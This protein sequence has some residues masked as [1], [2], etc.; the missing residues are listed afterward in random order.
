VN[1]DKIPAKFLNLCGILFLSGASALVCEVIWGRMLA[2]VLGVTVYGA[3]IVLVSFML[4]L[5][6]GSYAGGKI[7]DRLRR[8]GVFLALGQLFVCI[9]AIISPFLL[10]LPPGSTPFGFLLAGFL[11]LP[12]S[13]FWGA[14][15]P[16]AGALCIIPADRF[17][18]RLTGILN[19]VNTAGGVSGAAAA[20]FLLGP[21]LGHA[22]S[23]QFAAGLSLTASLLAAAGASGRVRAAS[24]AGSPAPSGPAVAGSSP[25]PVS[26]PSPGTLGFRKI[27]AAGLFFLSGFTALGYEVLWTRMLVFYIH[28][29]VYAF[30]AMLIC[31][32]AGLALGSGIFALFPVR[33]NPVTILV[34]GLIGTAASVA[35]SIRM[36]EFLP[37]LSSVYCRLAGPEGWLGAVGLVLL[38]TAVI[39]LIPVT[40]L[41]L[42]FPS[43]AAILFRGGARAGTGLGSLLFANSLGSA[44]GAA[45]VAFLVIP[46]LG[47]CGSF[48]LLMLVNLATASLAFF[49]LQKHESGAALRKSTLPGLAVLLVAIGVVSLPGNVF[50]SRT[51]E[52]FGK[53]LYYDEGVTGTVMVTERNNKRFLRFAD[54]RGTASTLTVQENRLLG[55]LPMLISPGAQDI[56]IIGFGAGNT[57]AAVACHP[58][59]HIDAVDLGAG[60]F[61]A[62]RYFSTNGGIVDDPRLSS[63]V[64]DG[65]T[66]LANSK[67]SYDVIIIDPPELHSAGVAYLFTKEFYELCRENLNPGGILVEWTNVMEL[68]TRELRMIAATVTSV[69]PHTSV[70]HSPNL[71]DWIMIADRDGVARSYAEFTGGYAREK[72]RNHLTEVK[73]TISEMATA[74]LMTEE[75][76]A[77]FGAG[78]LLSTDDKTC[79]DYFTPRLPQACFGI[80]NN[81]QMFRMRDFMTESMGASSWRAGVI[82]AVKLASERDS[83]LDFFSEYSAPEPGG[84]I[85]GAPM[86]RRVTERKRAYY[87]GLYHEYTS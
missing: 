36:M 75:T 78:S 2:I 80:D 64:E 54:G 81:S 1:F 39:E 42:V 43:I 60:T 34:S 16:I 14:S 3:T 32:I 38:Q 71:A 4:G 35:V 17:A 85:E 6:A 61:E 27:I 11:L 49:L 72:V 87:R 79:F 74:L 33:W 20:G 47:L 23:L 51:A 58:V 52:T 10:S 66:F 62:A 84:K 29:S 50:R 57:A 37:G 21:F 68:S 26:P 9:Y 86:I 25:S 82:Q 83:S 24:A 48:K 28:N 46:L 76:L 22:A 19:A 53:V 7:A 13:F 40:C 59:K 63:H 41:G 77:G 56:C 31:V 5:A 69:F 45:G 12:P 65:R 70:W 30:S 15:L 55:H 73:L 67:R 8:P 44:A 18:G